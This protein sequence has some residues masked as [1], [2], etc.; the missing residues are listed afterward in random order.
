MPKST[1]MSGGLRALDTNVSTTSCYFYGATLYSNGGSST[2]SLTVYDS[3]DDVT[4]GKTELAYI[5]IDA[6]DH[7][8]GYLPSFPIRASFGLRCETIGSSGTYI[9]YYGSPSL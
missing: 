6:G 4:G 9:T 5:K 7:F 1:I 3:A 8:G 2:M